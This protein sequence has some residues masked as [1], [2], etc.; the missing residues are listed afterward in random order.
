MNETTQIKLCVFSSQSAVTSLS[1]IV[2]EILLTPEMSF[3]LSG[4]VL[5]SMS[6][7]FLS[8]DF[9]ISQFIES[10]KYSMLEHFSQGDEYSL[11]SS[12]YELTKVRIAELK[13][14]ELENV[15][16]LPSFRAHIEAIVH[17]QPSNVIQLM[18]DD[19]YLRDYI[20]HLTLEIYAF[21]LKYH[22]YLKV[23]LVLV[24]DLPLAPLGRNLRSLYM[25]CNTRDNIVDT[26]LFNNCCRLLEGMAK[27][28]LVAK[29]MQCMNVIED[30]Q[31][32]YCMTDDPVSNNARE[33]FEATLDCF[34]DLVLELE[35]IQA[36]T[37]A[38][39]STATSLKGVENRGDLQQVILHMIA[40][41]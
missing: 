29:S 32:A 10:I 17:D 3:H 27:E 24:K 28:G 39:K 31:N 19:E 13:K 11:C 6:D 15:R 30:Y 21:F 41:R 40:W 34:N 8:Y 18:N 26:E 5:R 4:H 1:K 25:Q 2:E 9:T 35:N 22:C 14:I 33:A 36:S 20:K 16:K 12:S 23:L 7:V 37:G 38:K